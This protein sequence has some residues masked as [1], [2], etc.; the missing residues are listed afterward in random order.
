MSQA[1]GVEP[2]MDLEELLRLSVSDEWSV[3]FSPLL[4]GP[5][6]AQGGTI[7]RSA[8]PWKGKTKGDNE[9]RSE[10]LDRLGD[11]HPEVA[12]GLQTAIGMA[13]NTTDESGVWLIDKDGDTYPVPASAGRLAEMGSDPVDVLG[14]FGSANEAL[15]ALV[16]RTGNK[17][18]FPTVY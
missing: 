11:S 17:P 14:K 13:E 2:D 1:L 15:D 9:T 8:A 12:S 4:K 7:I 6:G 5:G 18:R 10:Y 3:Q 16:S